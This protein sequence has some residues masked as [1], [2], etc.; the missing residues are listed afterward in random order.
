M[1]VQHLELDHTRPGFVPFSK[2]ECRPVPLDLDWVFSALNPVYDALA[3]VNKLVYRG[4][5]ICAINGGL[6]WRIAGLDGDDSVIRDVDFLLSVPSGV[7]MERTFQPLTNALA[8]VSGFRWKNGGIQ[9]H[10]EPSIC[11]DAS[12]ALGEAE[13]AI[14]PSVKLGVDFVVNYG[15]LTELDGQR[16]PRIIHYQRVG[17]GRS[18]LPVVVNQ[19]GEELPLRQAIGGGRPWWVVG[20]EAL[21]AKYM[22][23]ERVLETLFMREPDGNM[24]AA[25]LNRYLEVEARLKRLLENFLSEGAVVGMAGLSTD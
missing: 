15:Y 25:I 6:S 14:S 7:P 2:V 18:G 10:P 12:E 9:L 19:K 24:A 16:G 11:G 23:A 5:L 17:W 4:G 22:G 13:L 8:E 1:A 3:R 20:P 21:V